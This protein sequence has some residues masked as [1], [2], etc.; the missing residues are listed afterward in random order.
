VLVR[1]AIIYRLYVYV[2]QCQDPPQVLPLHFSNHLRTAPS[3]HPLYSRQVNT[4]Y[5]EE[6][7]QQIKAGHSDS[8][9]EVNVDLRLTA[10]KPV[11]ASW[12]VGL[13]NHLSSDIGRRHVAKEWGKADIAKLLDE[14]FSLFPEDLFKVPKSHR[15][16]M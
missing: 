16:D 2:I 13:C 8:N 11:H 15:K 3:I 6:V 10:L 12:L 5:F 14:S 7:Q 4:W 1:G 9:G